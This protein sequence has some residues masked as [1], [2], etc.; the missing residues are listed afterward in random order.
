MN[1]HEIPVIDIGTINDPNTLG[2]LDDACREW[3]FF[4][5]VNHGI[6]E[7]ALARTLDHARTFFGLPSEQKRAISRTAENS[8]GFYDKELTKNTLDWKQIFDYGPEEGDARRPQW[9]SALP[10]FRSGVLGHYAACEALAFRLL[11]A[12][13]TNLGAMPNRLLE[14]FLP[15]HSSFLRLNYYP[16]CPQ[17]ERPSGLSTPL[18]GHL[19]LNHHTDAGALT[20]LL[21]DDQPGLEVFRDG[22]W[23]LVA[24]VR[25]ALVVNVGDVVQ[26][27]SNDRYKAALHRVLA[28]S[29][30]ERFSVPFFFCPA[31]STNYAPLPATTHKSAPAHYRA[32]NW[33]EFYAKRTAGDYADL[34]EEV[35]I[36]HY[37]I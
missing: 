28:N 15:R 30:A 2:E 31:Y 3:G 33:G 12:I 10:R 5:V 29:E 11:I 4:Q 32:I 17:P 1:T 8:W 16:P 35:Q 7:A 19:G 25:G 22:E 13:A 20:I 27:W 23:H 24:P 9:P 6:D 21:Q 34:G 26:V 18:G 14:G 36:S 37:G